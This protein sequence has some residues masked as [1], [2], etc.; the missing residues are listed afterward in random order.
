MHVFKAINQFNF[1][2]MTIVLVKFVFKVDFFT[3][4]Q[5]NIQSGHIING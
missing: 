5:W 4:L 3:G 2:H 1:V